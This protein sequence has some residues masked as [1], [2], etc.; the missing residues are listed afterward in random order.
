MYWHIVQCYVYTFIADT[1]Y[2]YAVF[3]LFADSHPC[4]WVVRIRF[5]TNLRP[6]RKGERNN[7]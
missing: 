2:L 6:F 7:A 3:E 1:G 5:T 4:V